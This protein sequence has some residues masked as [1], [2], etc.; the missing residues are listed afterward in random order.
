MTMNSIIKQDFE[1][2]LYSFNDAGWFN[3]TEAAKRFD[4]EPFAWVNQRETMDYIA[5]LAKHHGNSGFVQEINEIKHLDGKGAKSRRLVLDLVKRTGFVRTKPGAPEHGGGTWMHP[6]LAVPFARWLNVDFAVWCD[7]QI[8]G[9]IRNGIRAEGNANLLPLL[10]RDSAGVWELRFKP[11]YY[12]ALAKLT[13]TIYT[14][15]AGGTCPLYGYITD[16]WVYGCLLPEEVHAELKARRSESQKMH[17]WLTE[18]GQSLLD[19][20]ISLVQSIAN[21]STDRRDFEARMMLV[22]SRRGQLGFVY[23]KAA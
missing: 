13:G 22:S 17:Q 21:T 8:D 9:I 5:A 1:G 20:Q 18:G 7:L 15:H 10:L 2:H 3:A 4:K 14:G 6:K 12:Q 23:P 11:E 19:Q 16:R